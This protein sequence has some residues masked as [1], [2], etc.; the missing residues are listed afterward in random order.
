MVCALA[1]ASLDKSGRGNGVVLAGIAV[2]ALAQTALMAL[3]LTAD[4][5]KELASIEYWIMG[6]LNGISIYN[7]AGNMLLCAGCM[8]ALFALH[9]HVLLLW[10]PDCIL[11]AS[12]ALYS[13]EDVL[14]DPNLQGLKAV[15]TQRVYK[16]PSHI[17][18]W[19]SPVPGTILGSVWLAGM[20]HPERSDLPGADALIQEF[21]RTFY[22]FT[23][24]N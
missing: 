6:S 1:L 13:V 24:E 14:S 7:L 4:P 3:K 10:N 23:Y 15:Q 8:L 12:D 19:D 2:H 18:A 16:L 5:E 9:R 11:L 22:G 20:L 17:E 21:Y